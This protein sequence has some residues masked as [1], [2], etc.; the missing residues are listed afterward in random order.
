MITETMGVLLEAEAELDSPWE[1]RGVM[2]SP[3]LLLL[4]LNPTELLV[5]IRKGVYSKAGDS[6]EVLGVALASALGVG[7]SVEAS[8][9]RSS[10]RVFTLTLLA[11]SGTD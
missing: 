4:P 11:L 1:E 8:L 9:P 5:E 10:S 7:G 3:R 2:G 6:S